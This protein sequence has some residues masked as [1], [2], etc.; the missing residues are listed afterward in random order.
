MPAISSAMAAKYLDIEELREKMRS[1][2]AWATR[3]LVKVYG[4]KAPPKEDQPYEGEPFS[5]RQLQEG[6]VTYYEGGELVEFHGVGMGPKI[7]GATRGEIT[8]FSRDSRRRLMRSVAKINKGKAGMPSFL[9]V[10]YGQ[11]CPTDAREWKEHLR[12]FWQSFERR[13][14]KAFCV[15]RLEFQTERISEQ[16]PYGIPHFHFLIWNGPQIVGRRHAGYRKGC[17]ELLFRMV[18]RIWVRVTK[19]GEKEMAASTR[20]EMIRSKNGIFHY[21]SKYLGKVEQAGGVL[22]PLPDGIGRFWG[23]RNRAELKSVVEPK[24]VISSRVDWWRAKGRVLKWLEEKRGKKVVLG[25]WEGLSIFSGPGVL[26][27]AFAGFPMWPHP[28]SGDS[29][30]GL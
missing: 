30:A 4:W 12:K 19:G 9:T 5:L 2:S 17:N 16:F 8:E 15:W 21:L 7:D 22:A 27:M 10:T 6:Q 28:E 1:G 11:N 26:S 29:L 3:M 13:Y 18:R 20:M 14:P 25:H 24:T 23:W